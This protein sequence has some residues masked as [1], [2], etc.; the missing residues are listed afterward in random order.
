METGQV[1]VVLRIKGWCKVYLGSLCGPSLDN[2]VDQ[3]RADLKLA[4]ARFN[5]ANRRIKIEEVELETVGIDRWPFKGEA[6][7]SP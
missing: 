6:N 7:A 1:R 3:A 2:P 4:L 5:I